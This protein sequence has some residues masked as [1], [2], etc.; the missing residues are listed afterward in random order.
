VFTTA[1]FSSVFPREIIKKEAVSPLLLG[2]GR[3]CHIP[4]TPVDLLESGRWSI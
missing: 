4:L 3:C 2:I 1:L